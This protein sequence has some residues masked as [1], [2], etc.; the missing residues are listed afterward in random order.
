MYELS[1]SFVN[2]V[3]LPLVGVWLVE[4]IGP[5]QTVDLPPIFHVYS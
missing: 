5:L 4:P 2:K 1:F 3:K